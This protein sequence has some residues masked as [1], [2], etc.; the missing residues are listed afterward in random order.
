M[1]ITDFFNAPDGYSGDPRGYALNQA[2]HAVVVGLAPAMLFPAV[3]WFIPMVYVIWEVAQWRLRGAEP[4][5]C[6]EDLAYVTGGVTVAV[7]PIV[8]LPI[9]LFWLSG[10]ARR[11]S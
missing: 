9:A 5:D 6:V 4:W 1:K 11:V 3:M 8:A 10:I 7:A 2:G